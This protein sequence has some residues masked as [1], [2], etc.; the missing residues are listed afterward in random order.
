[1]VSFSYSCRSAAVIRRDSLQRRVSSWGDQDTLDLEEE[2]F[3]PSAKI[4]DR[5]LHSRSH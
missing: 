5:T 1:M 4:N 2:V 3:S